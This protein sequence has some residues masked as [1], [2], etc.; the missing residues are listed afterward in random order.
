MICLLLFINKMNLSFHRFSAIARVTLYDCA[1]MLFPSSCLHKKVIHRV[2][3]I[4]H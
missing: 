1:F 3:V 2:Y 4:H